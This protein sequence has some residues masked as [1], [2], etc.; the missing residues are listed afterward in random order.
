MT[1]VTLFIRKIPASSSTRELQMFIHDNLPWFWRFRLRGKI[2]IVA[3]DILTIIDKT[4]KEA[5]FHGLVTLEPDNIAEKMINRLNLRH[6]KG[7][8]VAVRLYQVRDPNNDRRKNE[9]AATI[10]KY[11]DQRL[12]DRRRA[13][14][15]VMDE[16]TVR[17]RGLNNFSRRMF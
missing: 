15:E 10:L 9:D 4:T 3:T 1:T 11:R 6:F 16:K 2:R 13:Q 7:R 8:R 5:E 14:L 17:T 12:R